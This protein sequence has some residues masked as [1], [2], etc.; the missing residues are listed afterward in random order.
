MKLIDWRKELSRDGHRVVL[1]GLPVAIHC[2]HYNINLHKTLE[3]ALG[4]E[5]IELI[6]DAAEEASYIAF[7]VLLNQYSRIKT[8]KSRLELAAANYQ[9]CGLGILHFQKI[10]PRGGKIVSTSSHHVTGWLAKNGRRDTPGCHF[11]R[12]WIAGV[13]EI[14]YNRGL[15]FYEIEEV[16]CKMMRDEACV[17]RVKER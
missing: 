3:E 11:C 12:G 13:L 4:S 15:G 2:H 8:I 7:N 5:G 9:N 6:Y 17:F 10:G 14:I 1:S 16:S